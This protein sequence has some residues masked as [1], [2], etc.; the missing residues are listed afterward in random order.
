M[1]PNLVLLPNKQF[2]EDVF[3]LRKQ[4]L[5]DNLGEKNSRESV[6]PHSTIIYLEKDITKEKTSEIIKQLDKLSSYKPI[7]LSILEIINWENK[8]IA[9]FDN[10]PIKKLK[11]EIDGLLGKNEIKFNEEY[12]K[13]FGNT[14]GDHMKL[15]RQVYQAKIEETINIFKENLPKNICFNR[16]AF[17]DYKTEEKDILWQKKLE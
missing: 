14:I 11:D 17:I 1:K 3:R 15:A 16:I 10:S 8:I 5:K 12:K 2:I 7:F 13:V 9:K 6:L 4:I